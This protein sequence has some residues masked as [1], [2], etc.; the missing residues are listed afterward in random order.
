MPRS[1]RRVP[2][3]PP[4]PDDRVDES[5]GWGVPPEDPEL[6]RDEDD[7]EDELGEPPPIPI[8]VEPSTMPSQGLQDLG[9]PPR[10]TLQAEKWAHS[11]LMR[12]AYETMMSSLPETLRRKEVRTILRDAKGHVTDAAR[13]DY[14][15]M[16]QHD[17]DEIEN[18]KRG[19]A[20]A[21][22]VAV[23]APPET[24]R[25]IPLIRRNE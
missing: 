11:V 15:Q 8:A 10:D 4:E 2:R 9:P 13:Y 17:K 21:V 6:D 20:S 7:D 18:R 12:Q 22:P 1:R 19:R 3:R 24:A 23:G 14:M 16:V 25:I 5:D